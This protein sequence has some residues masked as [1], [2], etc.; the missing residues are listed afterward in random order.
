GAGQRH[1]AYGE[2]G[3]QQRRGVPRQAVQLLGGDLIR[4]AHAG[5][6]DVQ[7][8]RRHRVE[9]EGGQLLL[10]VPGQGC[11][12]LVVREGQHP[13]VRPAAVRPAWAC[14]VVGHLVEC[15]E[16]RPV[17]GRGDR[18]IVYVGG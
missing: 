12:R 17:V 14:P 1:G 3:G 10:A 4:P 2:R 18:R 15:A 16:R 9:A 13:V 7:S 6:G 11:E 5:E 8:V